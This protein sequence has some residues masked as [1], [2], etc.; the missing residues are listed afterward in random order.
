MITSSLFFLLFLFLLKYILRSLKAKL[1]D[2]KN[3]E[4]KK[5][6]LIYPYKMKK[7]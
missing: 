1:S 4:K 7:F 5:K 3:G 6:T 2:F